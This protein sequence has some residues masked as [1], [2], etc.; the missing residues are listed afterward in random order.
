MM[1][2]DLVFSFLSV[3]IHRVRMDMIFLLAVGL[4]VNGCYGDKLISVRYD[5]Q[6]SLNKINRRAGQKIG[7]IELKNGRIFLGKAVHVTKDSTI[8]W[9]TETES[10]RYS[11]AIP[12]LRSISIQRGNTLRGLGYGFLIGASLGVLISQSGSNDSYDCSD[13]DGA[14]CVGRGG[15]AILGIILFGPPSGLIGL[16][17]GAVTR[18]TEKYEF[19]EGEH[20]P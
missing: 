19:E 4:I 10:T 11:A 12:E 20:K 5:S 6:Q 13:A 16:V 2:F 9:D 3:A 8:W 17:S 15:A 14:L 18:T 7:Q 1:K